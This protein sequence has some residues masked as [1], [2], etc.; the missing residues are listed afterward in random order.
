[1]EDTKKDNNLFFICKIFLYIAIAI[2]IFF[3]LSLIFGFLNCLFHDSTYR[4]GQGSDFYAF[5]QAGHNVLFGQ[6]PYEKINKYYVVPYSYNYRYLPFFAFTFGVLLNIFP[7]LV[8]YWVWVSFIILLIWYSCWITNKLCIQLDKPKWVSNVAIG[9]WLCFSPIYL[10]LYM[11]QITLFVGIL[12]FFSL[13]SEMKGKETQGAFFWTL[14][15][16]LKLVPFVLTPAILSS[17]RARKVFI[18]I[19]ST[20]IAIISF[21]FTLFLFFLEYNLEATGKFY[22]HNGNF[23]FKNFIYLLSILII[24]SNNWVVSNSRFINIILLIIF[25]GLSGIATVYSED[26]LVSI[27]LFA[28]SYFLVFS[29]IWEHHFTFL[30]PFIIIL[31]IRDESRIKWF[32][33]FLVFALPTPFYFLNVYNLWNLPFT[34]IYKASKT[35]PIL[36]FFTL[37]LIKAYKNPRKTNIIETFRDFSNNLYSDLKKQ[38][39]EKLPNVFIEFSNKNS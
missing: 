29:G 36:I 16:L 1:M 38:D 3:I 13:Y 8:A 21:G 26:Y 7:P 20:I 32:L 5:Y 30:L 37:L 25:F 39:P 27:S 11:G 34:L 2:H 10:E 18:S 15:G 31:W 28:S 24:P 35:V 6:S 19:I 23:D 17:G 14:G 22:N 9:M 33:I 4:L 12:T